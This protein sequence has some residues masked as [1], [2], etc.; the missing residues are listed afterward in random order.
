MKIIK[1]LKA[2]VV[3]INTLLPLLPLFGEFQ[4]NYFF[5]SFSSV[6]DKGD[7]LFPSQ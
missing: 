5:K 4:G 7:T 6:F 1:T 3:L 2:S